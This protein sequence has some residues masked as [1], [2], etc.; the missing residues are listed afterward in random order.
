MPT[1]LVW[2]RQDL[3]LS[4]N[5]ALFHAAQRGA[6]LPVFI[7]DESPP[8]T[9]GGASRW[10]LHHALASL[11]KDLQQQGSNLL[12]AQGQASQIIPQLLQTFKADAVYWNRRYAAHQ[13][14]EDKALKQQLR[15]NGI[16]VKSFNASLLHEPWDIKT[17]QE[18]CYKVFTP[19]WKRCLQRG[20][21]TETLP[22]PPL[23]P[24]AAIEKHSLKLADLQ[25]LPQKPDWAAGLRQKWQVSES[26]AQQR[27]ETFCATQL[28]HYAD[29]RDFPAQAVTSELSPYLQ[30]GQIS[31]R[32]IYQHSAA[33]TDPSSY[34][35]QRF[36]AELGWRE[37]SY[38]LLFHFPT[39]PEQAFKPAFNQFAWATDAAKLQA[40]QRGQTGYPLV[41][42]GMRQL[43]HSGIMHNRVRMVVASF[44]TKHLRIAWQEG[45]TWFWDTLVD[46]DLAS[47]AAS[48]QWVAGCGAD[49]APYFRIFNPI[50]QSE[51]FDAQGDYLR[52]WL[53]ELRNLPAK[54]MH[55]PWLLT[56]TQMQQY[57][58]MI[59]RDYPAPIVDHSTARDAA[60]SA[61]EA[62]KAQ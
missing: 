36:H 17:L 7:W 60:L 58:V 39:L 18:D 47:N 56:P 13:I 10:W 38:H 8:W 20:I 1:T 25:L 50:M 46:A 5:P 2:L 33:V 54:L 24:V 40:W 55:T 21:S 11:Q 4:D 26:A 44:L 28:S 22:S 27:L 34:A 42:A 16:E 41:D 49:A 61:Y 48:W 57:G 53:P 9:P 19:F 30:W 32:Q 23:T 35:L 3:R 6:V 51:K 12:I 43:W 14:A 15:D 37:F 59:G 45:E 52:T 29:A 62:I 31:P